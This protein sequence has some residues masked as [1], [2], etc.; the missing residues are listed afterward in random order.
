MEK[1]SLGTPATVQTA[2]KSLE[3]RGL[4]ERENG[5]YIL[6]DVFFGEWIKKKIL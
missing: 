1:H 5:S 2:I 4:V 3:K 6:S